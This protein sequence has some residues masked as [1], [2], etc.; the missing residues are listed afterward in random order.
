MLFR[1][2]GADVPAAGLRLGVLTD[3]SAVN[4]PPTSITLTQTVGSGSDTQSYVGVYAGVAQP[5]WYFFDILGAT[6]GDAFVLSFG[7][8]VVG[9]KPTVA[10]L[11]LDVVPEPGFA[12]LCALGAMGILLR[13]PRR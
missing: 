5:D 3:N 7:N 10:G 4:D 9:A 8:R 11:T 12:P 13:R 6:P 2:I 1:S